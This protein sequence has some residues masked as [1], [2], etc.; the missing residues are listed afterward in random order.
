MKKLHYLIF[1][2]VL[3]C[4]AS[5]DD[6]LGQLTDDSDNDV[7]D[8]VGID[9]PDGV[10]DI[11]YDLDSLVVGFQDIYPQANYALL[12]ELLSDNVVDNNSLNLISTDGTL[13]SY[14]LESDYNWYE[15]L[16]SFSSSN[17]NIT[18]SEW[19]LYDGYRFSGAQAG[20]FIY[21]VD[22]ASD[23]ILSQYSETMLKSMQGEAYVLRSFCNFILENIFAQSYVTGGD[24]QAMPYTGYPFNDREGTVALVYEYMLEDLYRGIELLDRYGYP[25]SKFRFNYE[26]VYAYAARLNVFM[27]RYEDAIRFAD[28]ALGSGGAA[29]S[30]LRDFTKFSLCSGAFDDYRDTWQNEDEPSVFMMSYTYS[31]MMRAYMRGNRFAYNSSA[32]YGTSF[33][34][35]TC[36]LSIP[37]YWSVSGLFLNERQDYGL[38]SAKIGETFEYTDVEAGIGYPRLKKLEFTAEETLLCR[39]EAKLMSGDLSGAL[40]DMRLWDNS[41]QNCIYDM[42]ED[43]S[44][45]VS[46]Y[47]KELTLECIKDFYRDGSYAPVQSWK[48]CYFDG[49]VMSD[50]ISNIA[51]LGY[52]VNGDDEVAVLRYLLHS[53]R[54]ETLFDGLRFFDLKRFGIEYQHNIGVSGDVP[55]MVIELRYDDPRRALRYD[56]ADEETDSLNTKRSIVCDKDVYMPVDMSRLRKL[57][58]R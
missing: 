57:S 36:T 30:K 38:V 18:D 1:T 13:V 10:G 20:L 2:F 16:F 23:S 54:L 24:T 33:F 15:N 37:P 14:N 49:T 50:M 31:L 22:N 6:F 29:A 48:S 43:G 19:F 46:V 40:D 12:S 25:E 45:D 8:S 53:R 11:K 39:A 51:L 47:Y 5:C 21:A 27:R 7:K 56:F 17:M 35:P 26:A 3:I 42:D 41:K 52:N 58:I 44:N 34:S 55:A 32:I 9:I 28:M 4:I